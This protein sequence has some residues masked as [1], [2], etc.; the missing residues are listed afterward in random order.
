MSS[1]EAYLFFRSGRHFVH[2]L[3]EILR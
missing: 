2:I 3:A 1:I